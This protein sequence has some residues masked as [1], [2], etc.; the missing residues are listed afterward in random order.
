MEGL[1]ALSL[2]CNVLQLVD[3]GC[4]LTYQ[5]RRVRNNSDP[6]EGSAEARVRILAYSAILKEPESNRTRQAS[7]NV[8][9]GDGYLNVLCNR[10]QTKVSEL[11]NM[12]DTMRVPSGS[13]TAQQDKIAVKSVSQQAKIKALSKDLEELYAEALRFY[14][15]QIR[16]CSKVT[17]R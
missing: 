10:A 8:D 4:K 15:L 3:Y 1:V 2:L 7:D 14:H 11:V 6:F 17:Y 12:L 16:N 13:S 9:D 5:L